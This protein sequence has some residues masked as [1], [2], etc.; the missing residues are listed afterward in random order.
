MSDGLIWVM[1]LAM[2]VITFCLR[3]GFLLFAERLRLPPWMDHGLRY[4]PAAV[5]AA[6]VA[7]AFVLPGGML[8]YPH[9]N[10]YLIAGLV[11]GIVAWRTRS[12]LWTLAV[13][14]PTLWFLQEALMG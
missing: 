11:A 9:Q 5:L 13:G 1:I 10:P 2:A 8:L 4:V 3:S 14:M 7:P 12:I 6:L